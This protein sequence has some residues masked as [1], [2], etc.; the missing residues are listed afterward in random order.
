M[1]YTYYKFK[2]L[3]CFSS[4][5][6]ILTIIYWPAGLILNRDL[7]LVCFNMTRKHTFLVKPLLRRYRWVPDPPRNV[8]NVSYISK[9]FFTPTAINVINVITSN[10]HIGIKSKNLVFIHSYDETWFRSPPSLKCLSYGSESYC[11]IFYV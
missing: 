8:F 6:I 4:L 11:I 10:K 9:L 2:F 5:T 1:S 7:R 3:H